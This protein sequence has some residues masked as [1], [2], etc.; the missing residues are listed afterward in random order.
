MQTVMLEI[1][2]SRRRF[3]YLSVLGFSADQTLYTVEHDIS[4]LSYIGLID[5]AF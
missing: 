5:Q 2:L 3:G 4:K 1:L